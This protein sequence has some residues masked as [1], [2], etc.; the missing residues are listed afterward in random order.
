MITYIFIGMVV[1]SVMLMWREKNWKCLFK[2]CAYLNLYFMTYAAINYVTSR[3]LSINGYDSRYQYICYFALVL[4]V[5]LIFLGPFITKKFWKDKQII[6]HFEYLMVNMSTF[7]LLLWFVVYNWGFVF[8]FDLIFYELGTYVVLLQTALAVLVS[9]LLL[10]KHDLFHKLDKFFQTMNVS[11]TASLYI[12]FIMAVGSRGQSVYMK[13]L[14]ILCIILLLYFCF[15][16]EKKLC[17][18]FFSDGKQQLKTYLL[19]T[20]RLLPP[21]L[22]FSVMLFCENSLEFYSANINTLPFGIGSFYIDFIKISI[23]ITIGGCALFALLKTEYVSYV[24]TFI[25]SI[26]LAI[27]IQV[28]FLNRNLG[29]TDVTTI[30]WADY[31]GSMIIGVIVWLICIGLPFFVNHKNEKVMAGISKNGSIFLLILQVVSIAYLFVSIGGWSGSVNE[32]AAKKSVSGFYYLTDEKV[33]N[34]SDENVVVFI[35]DTFSNDFMDLILE[36]DAH[37]LDDF[38]DFTYFSNYNGE[39]DGTALAVPFMLTGVKFDNTKSC[40]SATRDSFQSEHA[41]TFYHTLKEQ[42]I[43]ARLYTDI[44]TQSW[45]GVQNIKDYYSNVEVDESTVQEVLYDSVIEKM[46]RSIMYRITPMVVKPR[47]LVITDDF[48]WL[49]N[50]KQSQKCN[51]PSQDEF[52]ENINANGLSLCDDKSFIIYHFDGM[53]AASTFSDE[54]IVSCGKD[55][56]NIVVSY[57]EQLKKMGVYD[58]TTII[59]TADH[60]IHET[61]DGMQPIFMIKK[62]NQKQEQYAE[63]K[64]PIDAVDLLPTILHCFGEKTD[65]YGTTIYDIDETVKRERTAYVRKYDDSL[66]YNAKTANTNIGASFNCLYQ[67]N[68]VGDKEDLR[69]KDEENP[70]D[71]L[72]LKD[73]WW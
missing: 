67:F 65:N 39:Y 17:V 58:N 5:L 30:N 59:I 60:G 70:D 22:L 25:F 48:L 12:V 51:I 26:D 6:H 28:M 46:T 10:K 27:Y 47:F 62:A 68:Y 44:M 57:M 20:C 15:I 14:A 56:L 52:V 8:D 61:V 35:L 73:F 66:L 34:V 31:T 21:L 29:Q 64:A 63:S 33:Y 49:V 50:R 38:H 11:V 55:N 7:S 18:N 42:Q 24:T 71:I 37:A 41:K 2:A 19:K 36:K 13:I 54:E 53:H 16:Q 40:L 9:F 1:V 23:A 3:V 69:K 32:I 4:T 43:D 72:P 45:I